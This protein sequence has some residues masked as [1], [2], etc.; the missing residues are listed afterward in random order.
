MPQAISEAVDVKYILLDTAADMGNALAWA[1]SLGYRGTVSVHSFNGTE[2][3]RV[4][5][6]GPGNARPVTAVKGEVF[7]FHTEAAFLKSMSRQTFNE[8]YDSVDKGNARTKAAPVEWYPL[9]SA[10][11]LGTALDALRANNYTGTFST[12]MQN[13]SVVIGG[14]DMIGP[15]NPDGVKASLG[16]V[17]LWHNP[18]GF[19]EAMPRKSFDQTHTPQ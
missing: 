16:D 15:G 2:Y 13:G 3:W 19:V 1:L 4:E 10:A 7:I 18:P 14:I 9:E 6:N 12:E 17:L 11:D 5:L 8:N